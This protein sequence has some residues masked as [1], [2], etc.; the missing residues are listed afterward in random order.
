MGKQKIQKQ[1]PKKTSSGAVLQ[2][3]R[4]YYGRKSHV[5]KFGADLNILRLC[6]EQKLQVFTIQ[7]HSKFP[8][9]GSHG[10]KD[11]ISH[12]RAMPEWWFNEFDDDFDSFKYNFA[13]ATGK[14]SNLTVIDTDGVQ[15][16][17][18]LADLE[19]LAGEPLPK[20]PV[21]LTPN[22][23]KHFY[24]KYTPLLTTSVH[25][26]LKI[27][28]RNDGGYIVAPSSR[29]IK[30]VYGQYDKTTG[31]CVGLDGDGWLTG[32]HNL[33]SLKTF[34]SA[35]Y[36][37]AHSFHDYEI[38]ELPD[39]HAKALLFM[40]HHPT[41]I[42]HGLVQLP[43]ENRLRHIDIWHQEHIRFKT[44]TRTARTMST[45]DRAIRRQ[46]EKTLASPV[47][48]IRAGSTPDTLPTFAFPAHL[49]PPIHSTPCAK[50]YNP[51]LAEFKTTGQKLYKMP[52]YHM[53]EGDGRNV[54]MTSVGGRLWQ[55]LNSNTAHRDILLQWMQYFN[56]NYYKEPLKEGELYKIFNSVSR[57][58]QFPIPACAANPATKHK[59]PRPH[60]NVTD[61]KDPIS[62]A[63]IQGAY[64]AVKDGK[65]EKV[66]TDLHS[67]EI[68]CYTYPEGHEYI[69][70]PILHQFFPNMRVEEISKSHKMTFALALGNIFQWGRAVPQFKGHSRISTQ[71]GYRLNIA[72]KPETPAIAENS[73]LEK[74]RAT[75]H[76]TLSPLAVEQFTIGH[77]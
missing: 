34:Y 29:L 70:L 30:F 62:Q 55:Y 24:F 25:N 50:E 7:Q 76:N 33:E 36:V 51:T 15:G 69:L 47:E 14:N 40:M 17:R 21:V 27:D 59:K 72:P 64:Q 20:T 23:G 38:A 48:S 39:I 32:H 42:L 52:T 37:F 67:N 44:T 16:Q 58:Q 46:I 74:S 77:L 71:F 56:A 22:D 1:Y 19:E 12:L 65:I 68:H 4:G 75:E 11:A 8:F 9:K 5:P 31:E 54:H 63:I 43:L 61:S 6:R 18:S 45:N 49:F 66:E 60:N 13:I 26:R 53:I 41:D 73:N 2:P 28:I 3:P 35:E 10:S 57:Y